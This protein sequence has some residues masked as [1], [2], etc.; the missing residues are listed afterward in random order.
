MKV[1]YDLH[2]HS[3]LSPCADKDMTPSNIAGC[4]KLSGL[5]MFAIA[6]HNSILNVKAAMRAAEHYGVT[7]VPAMELQTAEDIHLL[8]LF[9]TFEG[10]KG[11]YDGLSFARY[12][13]RPEIFGRQYVYDEDDNIIAEEDRMLL[14]S[15]FISSDEAYS[16]ARAFGGAAVPAHID[17]DA[18]SMLQILGAVT[19]EFG[20]V[21]LSGHADSQTESLWRRTHRVIVNSDAH[22][23][24]EIGG[25]GEAELYENSAAALIDYLLGDK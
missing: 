18:N 9:K 5:N 21:E 24:A 19:E 17:R 20:A 4:A 22:T 12:V 25:R 6:D 10:L 15:A 13:N 8:C 7:A 1:R 3:G 14:A 16:A 23:L 11:F 2:I